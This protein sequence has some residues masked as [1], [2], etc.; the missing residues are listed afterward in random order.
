MKKSH[1]LML[2]GSLT[3]GIIAAGAGML[4]VGAAECNPSLGDVCTPGLTVP[5][6][7]DPV[8]GNPKPGQTIPVSPT[9]PEK[10]TTSTSSTSTTVAESTTTSSTVPETTVW[11]SDPTTTTI[12]VVTVPQETI[13]GHTN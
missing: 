1:E 10:G 11:T 9:M 2:V 4:A 7:V 8:P 12:V 13:P 6:D 5:P 3:G